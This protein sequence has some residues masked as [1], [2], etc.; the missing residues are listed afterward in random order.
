VNLLYY[1]IQ[2]VSFDGFGFGNQVIR[3][4]SSARMVAENMQA[5]ADSRGNP[6]GSVFVVWGYTGRGSSREVF[7]T[8]PNGK[9]VA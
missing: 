5:E 3:N 6:S 2:Q 9:A 8:R 4:P 7:R 1:R